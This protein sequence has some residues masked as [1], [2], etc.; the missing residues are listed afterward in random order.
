MCLSCNAIEP[1]SLAD[2]APTCP[3]VKRKAA[4][5]D[6][7]D[8]LLKSYKPKGTAGVQRVNKPGNCKL[9]GERVQSLL[10]HLRVC[11]G[12]AAQ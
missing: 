11:K 4:E 10:G 3:Q 7:I 2:H 8:R 12:R 1:K 5:R 9:C 6:G